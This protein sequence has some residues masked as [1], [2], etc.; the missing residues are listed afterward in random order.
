M[1][2]FKIH[3]EIR[4][5]KKQALDT[6]LETRACYLTNQRTEEQGT[7]H[8]GPPGWQLGL[9]LALCDESAMEMQLGFQR[10]SSGAGGGASANIGSSTSTVV[11]DATT[12][13]A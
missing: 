1:N 2:N 3:L 13:L 12:V 7:D 4:N 9:G 8:E 6:K 10:G 11:Q 5:P